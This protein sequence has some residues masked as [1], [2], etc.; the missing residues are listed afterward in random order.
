MNLP[1]PDSLS[2]VINQLFGPGL[3]QHARL[4]TLASAQEAGLPESLVVERFHGQESVNDNFQFEVD[5]LSVSTDLDLKQ[6]IGTELTL[7]LLQADGS[8]RAWHGYCTQ[9]SWLGADGGLARYRLRLESFL[10][11]LD[12]R[13]DSFLFQDMSVTDIASAVLKEYPQANFALDVTQTLTKRDICTQYR[14]SDFAFLRRILASEGLNF[15]FEHQQE[16]EQ[17]QASGQQQARHKLVIFDREAKAPDLPGGDTRIRFH[18][19]AATESSDAITDFSAVRS[20]RSNAVALASW[21]PEKISSPSAEENS[22]LDA[23]EVPALPVYDGTG[24]QDF[25]DQEAAAT[26]A[27]LMLQAL[28]MQNKRFEGAGAARQLS[29]GTQFT[30]SQHERYPEGE[31]RFKLLSVSHSARNNFDSNIAQIL[32]QLVPASLG[33]LFGKTPS[34]GNVSD[35]DLKAGT[36]RNSFVAVRE[37]VPIVPA[38][39]TERLKPT[40]RGTQTA[41]VTGLPDAAVTT[42]RNHRVKVQFH[43]Q[44]GK[45]PNPG[46]LRETGNLDDKDGNA[47]G[48]D[49]SGTWVRVAEAQSGPNWGSQFTPRI[50]SEVLID[51]IEGD[52]DRPVV[53]AQLYNGND[54]P[55]FPAGAESDANHAG[56]ISGWHSTAHD[57]SGFNQWVVDDTQSQLRMRL[58][59][60]QGKS[61]LNLGHLIDQADT[62][63]QRGNYRGQGFELRTDAWGVV[64]GAEG[65]LI[66]STAR[67]V[68]GASVTSTQMDAHEAVAQLKG[69]Q[70]LAQTM[71]EAA[72]QQQALHSAEALQAKS[73]FISV[74]DPQDQGKHP[75]SV[76]G[77]DA[78]KSQAGSRESDSAQPVE[79]FSKAAVLME[80]PSN[81]N[82]ASAASTVLY[83]GENLHWTT[84][85]DTHWTAADTAS[86]AAGKAAT[87]FAHDGGIQAFA[88]NGPVSLQAHTDALE[89]LADKD[90]SVVSVNEGIE[91]KARQK[92]VLQAGQASVTL[93]GG[94]ITF[95]CPGTFSV[96]GG[97]HA[98]PGGA[99]VSPD[100]MALPD[101]KYKLFDEAFV[102]KD[103]NGN[104]L[105][106]VPYRIKSS[107]GDQLA[108]TAKDGMS[109]RVSTEA[110]ENVEFAMEWFKVVP[111]KS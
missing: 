75:A 26:H 86:L 94:N 51:F 68:A 100:L 15:R 96:K 93:E 37:V 76:N 35:D 95:A 6:F 99:S 91:I 28:E 102:V 103:P 109:E 63:A 69:A 110:S 41:L 107:A 55:P 42:D 97:T 10:A 53:V 90:V 30:L 74:I 83:A 82:W 36:Y 19:I 24:Q 23:G 1:F 25:A 4:I 106:D 79:K 73:D 31:N 92:I 29:A 71:G 17:G 67:P 3:S 58:A 7:R 16:G 14:E 81:V 12:R 39:I 57:G 32:D 64:R 78:F 33:N 85:G 87:L 8:R 11:F 61:Q 9:A 72:A 34:S 60:S 52:I 50:G 105:S 101:T 62:G 89:I 84:Q 98:F 21:H 56:T 13:R 49:A 54:V 43:W 108:A 2:S 88:G 45:S 20:V 40:A 47:P 66:S 111:A 38:A 46:G 80:S 48:N 5:A 44:R 27:Q 65:L 77:Q 59:S 22:S 104:P 70:Q 18:R